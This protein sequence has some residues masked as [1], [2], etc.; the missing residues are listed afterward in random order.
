MMRLARPTDAKARGGPE[1]PEAAVA[2]RSRYVEVGGRGGY[3]W[4][5][6]CG[7]R[8]P[9]GGRPPERRCGGGAV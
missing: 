6:T 2:A 8:P 4:M 9:A 3:G 1:R 7:R 5:G